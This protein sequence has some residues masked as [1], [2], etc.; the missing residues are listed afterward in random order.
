MQLSSQAPPAG[1]AVVRRGIYIYMILDCFF[2]YFDGRDM[3][4]DTLDHAAREGASTG[5][6]TWPAAGH[7]GMQTCSG[8]DASWQDIGFLA[9]SCKYGIVLNEQQLVGALL[10]V[11]PELSNG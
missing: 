3:G 9:S 8:M 6:I 1:N 7:S 10:G 4:T 11:P 2:F 5:G